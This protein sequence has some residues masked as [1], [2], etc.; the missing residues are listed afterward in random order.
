MSAIYIILVNIYIYNYSVY[1]IGLHITH[2]PVERNTFSIQRI[3]SG[4]VGYYIQSILMV[5][6]P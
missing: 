5:S 4:I 2:Y 6:N 3:C 1:S